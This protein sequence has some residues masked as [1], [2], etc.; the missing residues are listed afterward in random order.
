MRRLLRSKRP[1]EFVEL[2]S[3]CDELGSLEKTYADDLRILRND[4]FHLR[5]DGESIKRFF[6]DDGE[7]LDWAR[8]LHAAY[9]SF[10]SSYRI[11]AEVHYFHTGRF[12]ESQ[13]RAEQ[14]VRRRRWKAGKSDNLGR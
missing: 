2:I 9:G 11:L 6:S 1:P 12:G 3:Q 10:F 14:E 5:V 8:R 4:T 7:R 13:F